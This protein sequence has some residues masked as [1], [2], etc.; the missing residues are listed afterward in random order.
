MPVIFAVLFTCTTVK[1]HTVALCCHV[2]DST[3]ASQFEVLFIKNNHSP[4]S[5]CNDTEK[6]NLWLHSVLDDV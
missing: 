1:P 5:M 3:T 4:E 6:P 2:I